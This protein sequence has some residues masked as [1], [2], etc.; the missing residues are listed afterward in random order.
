[1]TVTESPFVAFCVEDGRKYY[2]TYELQ[3]NEGD[4]T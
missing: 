4:L 2:C 3:K 1:M